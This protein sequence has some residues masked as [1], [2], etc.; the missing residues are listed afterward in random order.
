M[1]N[2]DIVKKQIQQKNSYKPF[3]SINSIKSTITDMDHFP[4]QR[5]F[6]GSYLSDNPIVFE[7]EAGYRILKNNCYK[8]D[9]ETEVIPYPNHCFQMP[10]STEIP[11]YPQLNDRIANR[12]S[13][14]LESNRSCIVQYR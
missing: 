14:L 2:L 3:Y 10:C 1:S 13:V 11:C 8:F 12:D 4:Y 9:K 7:R 5:F 6:R